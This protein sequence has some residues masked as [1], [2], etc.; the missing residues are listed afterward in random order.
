MIWA[1]R[2]MMSWILKCATTKSN[3]NC[4]SA[5]QCPIY[6]EIPGGRGTVHFGE[7]DFKMGSHKVVGTWD[8][9]GLSDAVV[10]RPMPAIASLDPME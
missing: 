4:L 7:T 6:V 10:L 1:S 9:E 8:M 5:T 2:P 3:D